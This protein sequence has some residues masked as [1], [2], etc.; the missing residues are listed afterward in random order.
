MRVWGAKNYGGG[1]LLSAYERD[2]TSEIYVRSS[3]AVLRRTESGADSVGYGDAY[4]ALNGGTVTVKGGAAIAS[5]RIFDRPLS[6]QKR[7]VST[8]G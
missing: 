3:G 8:P 1:Q 7:Q 5:G 4:C 2:G 6:L